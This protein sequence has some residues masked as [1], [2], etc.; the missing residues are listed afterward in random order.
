MENIRIFITTID[1]GFA[2]NNVDNLPKQIKVINNFLVNEY[3][4]KNNEYKF[5]FDDESLPISSNLNKKIALLYVLI[6][7]KIT[8]L[9]CSF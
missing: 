2:Q 1:L 3:N 5:I 8:H 4:K 6:Y 9:V 7:T